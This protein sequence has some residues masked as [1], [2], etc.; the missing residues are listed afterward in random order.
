LTN[1]RDSAGLKSLPAEVD[2]RA[3]KHSAERVN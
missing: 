1:A 3:V 2:L